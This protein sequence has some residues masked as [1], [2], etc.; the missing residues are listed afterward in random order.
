[1]RLW[2]SIAPLRI[3]S[4]PVS[5]AARL[6]AQL[7]EATKA[8]VNVSPAAASRAMFGVGTSFP[9]YGEQSA[10]PRSSARK[11]T[12]SGLLGASA[13]AGEPSPRKANHTAAPRTAIDCSSARAGPLF[14]A[15]R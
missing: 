2:L 13:T 6:G 9:P 12:T 10:Q 4:S 8:W 3:G 15:F 7:G 5:R 14:G 11:R 1:G